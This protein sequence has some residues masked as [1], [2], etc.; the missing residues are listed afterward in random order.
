MCS[1]AAYPSEVIMSRLRHQP[2]WRAKA[3][4]CLRHWSHHPIG[5]RIHESSE[6]RNMTGKLEGKIALV[7]GGNVGLGQAA[8]LTLAREG[9][10]VVIAARRVPEGHETVQRIHAA[11][12]DAIFVQT[13]VA[14]A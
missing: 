6:E 1:G 8:A 9:A 13:D 7:T 14:Q 3:V 5:A 10:K 11:G 2:L 12:G 4:L